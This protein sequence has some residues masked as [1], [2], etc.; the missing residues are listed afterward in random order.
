MSEHLPVKHELP[1]TPEDSAEPIERQ[2]EAT[3]ET[4]QQP[5]ESITDIQKDVE[6]HASSAKELT[7]DESE[8]SNA[9]P[10]MIDRA[11]KSQTYRH[12]IGKIQASLPKSQ[13]A[14][15]K[16]VHQPFI[17]SASEVGSKTIARPSG[18]LGG[19]IAALIGSVII[20]FLS[21]KYGFTYNFFVLVL[22]YAAGFI[23]GMI[24]ELG[25][26]ALRKARRTR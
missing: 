2:P 7:V 12:T 4:T 20:V 23:A 17:E 8:A 3:A 16:V 25:I 19:G 11:M 5:Q 24:V 21:R 13:R 15:S 6:K 26:Y 9:Q 10:T 1:S 14:F 22:L 18:I